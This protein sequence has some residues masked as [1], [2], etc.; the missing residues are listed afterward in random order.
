MTHPHKMKNNN[1]TQVNVIN[2]L[3]LLVIHIYPLLLY[4]PKSA[5]ILS[6]VSTI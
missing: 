6:M 3:G 2:S 5:I 1:S 4:R